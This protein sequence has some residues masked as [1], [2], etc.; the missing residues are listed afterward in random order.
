MHALTE[1]Q[2]LQCRERERGREGEGECKVGDCKPSFPL[3]C[4]CV[5]GDNVR[6]AVCVCV[7]LFVG[8]CSLTS[9]LGVP[10]P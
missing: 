3:V 6:E 4:V 8:M 9:P 2:A 1:N 7:F 5:C 10:T